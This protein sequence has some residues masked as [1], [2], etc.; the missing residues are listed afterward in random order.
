[1]NVKLKKRFQRK[2]T[3]GRYAHYWPRAVSASK[4]LNPG[5]ELYCLEDAVGVKPKLVKV[6]RRDDMFSHTRGLGVETFIV[7]LED[8]TE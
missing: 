8:L 2:N 5:D 1:M 3:K 7:L 4:T 6:I